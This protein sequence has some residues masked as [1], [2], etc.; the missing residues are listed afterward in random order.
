[1]GIPGIPG[2]GQAVAAATGGGKGGGA[3]STPDFQAAAT[4]TQTNAFGTTSQW[5]K[6]AD[7]Q[8]S[9]H[10]SFGGPVGQAAQ[11]MEGQMANAWSKPL[12]NGQQAREGAQ[13]AIYGQQ[14]SMLDP[15]WQQGEQQFNSQMAAQG[16]MP[17]SQAFDSSRGNFDRAKNNAYQQ[18]QYGSIIGG[19]QEAQ[20]NQQ[21]DINSR[22]APEQ[23]LMGLGALTNQG[24]NSLLPAAIAQYQG[25]LQKYGIDQQG[26]NSTMGGLMGLGGTLGSAAML[27]PAACDERLKQDIVRY[28]EEALPGVPMASFRYHWERPGTVHLGVIAQDVEKCYPDLV[29]FDENGYRMVPAYLLVR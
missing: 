12:D 11:G 23:G 18:A 27:A 6:G 3:P 8:Y 26:K 5:N 17:G 1:M 15:Q 13:K 9:Q 10:Q 7:G 21:M 2:P 24:N 4:P 29:T 28:S 20:R 14:T 19:G 16:L 22:M 25:G